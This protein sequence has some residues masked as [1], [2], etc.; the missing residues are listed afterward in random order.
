MA[1]SLKVLTL[2]SAMPRLGHRVGINRRR[3]CRATRSAACGRWKPERRNVAPSENGRRT[4][5]QNEQQSP[6]QNGAAPVRNSLK[7]LERVKGIEPSSS[8]WKILAL[9]LCHP[10]SLQ[11]TQS[12]LDITGLFGLSHQSVYKR[13]KRNRFPCFPYASQIWEARK[14]CFRD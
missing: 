11:T 2:T 14:G 10:S 13:R 3:C 7:S 5:C 12:A 1:A 6:C 8:A 9:T 4:I